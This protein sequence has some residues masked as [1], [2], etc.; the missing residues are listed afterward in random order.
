[1]QSF[2]FLPSTE[3]VYRTSGHRHHSN[4]PGQGSNQPSTRLEHPP[5]PRERDRTDR[6]RGRGDQ[7]LWRP[8]V[9]TRTT[10]YAVRALILPSP[11]TVVCH[12]HFSIVC[13]LLQIKAATVLRSVFNMGSCRPQDFEYGED[14]GDEGDYTGGH[15]EL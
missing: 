5:P 7:R 11:D 10:G 9:A 14:Y 1:M 4:Q 3:T 12:S 13:T 15:D 6:P 8:I 2:V